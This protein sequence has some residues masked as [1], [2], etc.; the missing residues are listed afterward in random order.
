MAETASAPWIHGSGSGSAGSG[1][2]GTERV[3][4]RRRED[5]SGANGANIQHYGE[6]RV[7]FAYDVAYFERAI[8]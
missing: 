3:R 6:F 4:W 1:Y 2:A 7:D 5:E 8:S